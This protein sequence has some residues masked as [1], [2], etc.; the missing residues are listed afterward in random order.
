MTQ[1]TG[2][3]A[4]FCTQCGSPVRPE[5]R[6]CTQCGAQLDPAPEL[7]PTPAAPAP[8]Q[9]GRG[10]GWLIALVC[11]LVLATVFAAGAVLLFAQSG[12]DNPSAAEATPAHTHHSRR[13]PGTPA[14]TPT[15]ASSSASAKPR[16]SYRCWNGRTT[17]ALARCG[18][19]S[20]ERGLA[21]VFTG[22]DVSGC[23]RGTADRELILRCAESLPDGTPVT[24][25]LSAWSNLG[26][27]IAH[28]DDQGR[29][30][31]QAI[32]GDRYL[33]TSY[34]GRVT[35][36]AGPWKAA[37]MYQDAGYSM[38]LYAPSEQARQEAIREFGAMRPRAQLSGTKAT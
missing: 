37:L 38:S 12:S 17:H 14:T 28:Y 4:R 22:V 35:S 20:G 10:R 21:W 23:S 15:A 3:P 8:G 24:V 32:A 2:L 11:V 34:D 27:A 5:Q 9:A 36:E 6:W 13:Q 7:Q 19:P 1:G 29:A 26:S 31:R 18:R 25:H 30:I 16:P 33:W